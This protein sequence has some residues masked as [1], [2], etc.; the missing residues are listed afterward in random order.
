MSD[1]DLII[2]G[3]TVVDGTGAPGRTADVAISGGVITDVGP[4]AGSAAR[5]S[6]PTDCWSRPASSTSI[7]T[8]TVKR[9]GAS[10]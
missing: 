6:M 10:G 7:R 1:H 8:T 2:R 3:G 4:V 9:R 5:T